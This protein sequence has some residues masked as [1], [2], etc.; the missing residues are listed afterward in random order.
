MAH[1]AQKEC[2]LKGAELSCDWDYDGK[3]IHIEG[4]LND[5]GRPVLTVS[6]ASGPV[7]PEV[8]AEA[9]K[10]TLDKIRPKTDEGEF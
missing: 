7:P 8:T 10:R 6:K 9:E 1:L 4:A 2:K 3:N 5:K